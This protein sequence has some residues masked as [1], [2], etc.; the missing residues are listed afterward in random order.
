MEKNQLYV[1]VTS[2][3]PDGYVNAIRHCINHFNIN[4]EIYFVYL[5]EDIDKVGDAD[6]YISIVIKKVTALL[7]NLS[8]GT[9]PFT[10][11]SDFKKKIIKP[12]QIEEYYK[13][14]YGS[15]LT[16]KFT[17]K[18][19]AYKELENELKT[20]IAKKGVFDVTGFQK[21]YLIDVYTLLHLLKN[22]TLY[23]FKIKKIKDRTYDDKE[24]IHNLID[25]TDYEYENISESNVTFGTTIIR[26]GDI[27]EVKDKNSTIE[28]I[29]EGWADSHATI[30]TNIIRSMIIIPILIFV[31][32]FLNNLNNWDKI[33]PWTFLLLA[34]VIWIINLIVQMISGRNIEDAL[35]I[36]NLHKF[37]KKKKLERIKAN[38]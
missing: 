1:F 8:K 26:Q 23:Y 6:K 28:L 15:L 10:D 11:E 31:I 4:N 29:S 34:P 22:S 16:L 9:Y 32:M 24:L 2:N 37:L 7:E 36:E 20:M 35:K 27:D 19:I 14:I 3:V 33:E 38:R 30:I 13:K 18:T 12:I 17:P 21:D 5:Y 25:K